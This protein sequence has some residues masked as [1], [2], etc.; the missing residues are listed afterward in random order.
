MQE[1]WLDVLRNFV[2]FAYI[3]ALIPWSLVSAA[4]EQQV[5]AE[6]EFRAFRLRHY[7]FSGTQ[8]GSRNSKVSWD[9]VS[10]GTDTVRKAVVVNWKKLVGKDVEELLKA[11]MGAVMVV[12]PSDVSSMSEGDKKVNSHP[13]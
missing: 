6:V 3:F 8:Y 12:I 11:P 10:L 4:T 2:V 5:A 9:A 7:D 13:D 1:D